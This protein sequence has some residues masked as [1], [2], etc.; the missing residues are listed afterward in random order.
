LINQAPDS[1]MKTFDGEMVD[2]LILF[3]I[4]LFLLLGTYE[5]NALWGSEV[6]LWKDCVKK[7]PE[8]ERTHHNLGYAFHEQGKVD[9][10]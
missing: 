8:K 9:E 6:T 5:R 7:S 10:A 1:K 3:F 4:V 2:G